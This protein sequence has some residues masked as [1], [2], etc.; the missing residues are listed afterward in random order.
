MHRKQDLA[1]KQARNPKRINS[2]QWFPDHQM[3]NK[4]IRGCYCLR[5]AVYVATHLLV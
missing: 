2:H 3:L 1:T 4:A 5:G